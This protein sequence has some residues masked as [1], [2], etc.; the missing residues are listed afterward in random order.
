MPE[1]LLANL[2]TSGKRPT[3]HVSCDVKAFIVRTRE[4]Y[5]GE[6]IIVG[7]CCE[8]CVPFVAGTKAE[9]FLQCMLFSFVFKGQIFVN[10]DSV[11]NQLSLT[12]AKWKQ[13]E[14][15]QFF[16]H[17]AFFTWSGSAD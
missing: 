17:P 9:K 16:T 2:K 8:S 12:A 6:G 10:V 1:A 7:S 4:N 11:V 13:P 14:R 3:S 5:P 15:A